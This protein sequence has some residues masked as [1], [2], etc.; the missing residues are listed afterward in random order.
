MPRMLIALA[1][2]VILVLPLSTSSEDAANLDKYLN[3]LTDKKVDIVFVFD[4]SNSMGGE[5]N[6]LRAIAN[7][8]A[9]DLEA[10]HIDYH[11]GLVEFR[12]FSITCGEG[13][14][15]QC[16]SPG[17]FAYLIKGNGTLT[18]EISTFN[19]WLE[20]LEA[21]GGGSG[22]P[23]AI[24][25]ALRHA[26]S[27]ILW[28]EDAEKEIIL[29]TDAGPHPDGSCC[30]AE[31]DTLEGT[32]FGLMHLGARANVI[33]PDDESLRKIAKDTGGQF[34][35]IR[36]GLSLKPL[37]EK[38]TEAMSNSFNVTADVIC[39]NGILKV[40][41]QLVGKDTIPYL[42]GKTDV[43]MYLKQAGNRS[44]YNLSYDQALRA[45]EGEVPDV[46][47]SVDL[48]IYG[49]VGES[50]AVQKVE[51]DCG[52]CGDQDVLQ[53]GSNQP[54]IIE[55]L[56]ATQSNAKE[57]NW[58]TNATD[59]EGDTILYKYFLNNKS[60]TDWIDLD[61]WILNASD[62][63]VGENRVEVQIKDGK[64]SVEEFDDS[65]SVQFKL[66]SMKLMIQTW[67]KT[68]GGPGR[69]EACSAQQINDGG[70][71]VTGL[72]GVTGPIDKD[73]DVFLF[74][75][76][77]S[78][79]MEWYKYLKNPIHNSWGHMPL[80]VQQTSD[81]G[82]AIFGV[83]GP[84]VAHQA[85]LV[86]TDSKGNE[87]WNRTYGGKETEAIYEG[88]QTSDGG[89]ILA[90]YTDSYGE[91]RGDILLI[92][93]DS[94]GNVLWD[95]VWGGSDLDRAHSVKQTR[96]GGYIVAGLGNMASESGDRCDAILIKTDSSGNKIW[97]RTFGEPGFD[98]L[99]SVQQTDDGGYILAGD[100]PDG[101]GL[102]YPWIIKTDSTGSKVW[103]RTF[104]SKHIGEAHS[105]QQTTDGGYVF[106]GF[107]EEDGWLIKTDSIGNLMWERT[108]GGS[109]EDELYSVNETSD[110]GLIIAGNTMSY[111]AGY[112]DVWLI[113]TDADGNVYSAG[114]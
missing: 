68:F 22:G 31:G 78:G 109:K 9:A 39:E 12:D 15:V 63:N 69:E 86:K 32:I 24:L 114:S 91:G 70:Y 100:A 41:V 74:E 44:R 37:L 2:L 81:R 111:G 102:S 27:D 38:I 46:C 108:I 55:N 1:A 25:A 64:H 40:E 84:L 57:I 85:W 73:S 29:L 28:R 97:E 35:E 92:K 87:Q 90:G 23:E 56:L 80:S 95:K 99:N 6:E 53:N 42:S 7:K 10:S 83:N 101:R 93:T 66:S 62:G 17:D 58:T 82:Y 50:S 30:N 48:S 107:A 75:T 3:R 13:K 76:D 110:E 8:F 54:P 21:G 11:L 14:S 65:K 4:T 16:G 26:G 94:Y 45:Y 43:W 88:Q 79:N 36:S 103:E 113:K 105:V 112:K 5:I 77:S 98:N 59:S 19:S 47:G 33:G 60:M 34:F 51:S 71:I 72:I 18:S 96:D 89:F 20:E 49:R 104:R 106:A 67:N 61:K 52:I